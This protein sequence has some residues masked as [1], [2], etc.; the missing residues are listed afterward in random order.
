MDT[1]K[2]LLTKYPS[3]YEGYAAKEAALWKKGEHTERASP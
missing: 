3:G 1:M 2:N